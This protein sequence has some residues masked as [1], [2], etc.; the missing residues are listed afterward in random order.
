MQL[1][2]TSLSSVTPSHSVRAGSMVAFIAAAGAMAVVGT[3]H[4]QSMARVW[5]ANVLGQASPPQIVEGVTAVAL[6][7]EHS[8]ALLPNGSIR[9]WGANTFNGINF[10][11]GQTVEPSD[12]GACKAIAAVPLSVSRS[13]RMASCACGAKRILTARK[14]FRQISELAKPSRA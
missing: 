4:A 1:K 13:A 10:N 6:S 8:L 2:F 7:S 3:A 14:Q 12:L 5:G 9:G 11:Y